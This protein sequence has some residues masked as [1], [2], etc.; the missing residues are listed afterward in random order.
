MRRPLEHRAQKW[1]PVF[2]TSD[3][4]TNIWSKQPEFGL[5][6]PGLIFDGRNDRAV[7]SGA[8]RL[9]SLSCT[10]TGCST[11][12]AYAKPM[13]MFVSLA[14]S[15]LAALGFAPVE[16]ASNQRRDQQEAWDAHR[17]GHIMSLREIEA[18]VVPTMRGAQYIGVEF[19]SISTIY[20]LKFLRD[21]TV[22]W[23]EVDGRSGQIVGRTGN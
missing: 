1:E 7:D 15:T 14:L 21:G 18:R 9:A 10:F 13:R 2:G 5:L 11:R 6:A 23:V 8:A 17:K 12:L 20:T 4:T 22:I 3:A 19:D 16:G